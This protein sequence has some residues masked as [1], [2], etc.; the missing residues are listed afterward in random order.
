MQVQLLRCQKLLVTKRRGRRRNL[1]D[2]P[3]CYQIP[4]RIGKRS[5]FVM[6]ETQQPGLSL[7]LWYSRRMP[8][9]QLQRSK[10]LTT[11]LF[12]FPDSPSSLEQLPHLRAGFLQY[13]GSTQEYQDDKSKNA[14]PSIWMTARGKEDNVS[15]MSLMSGGSGGYTQSRLPRSATPV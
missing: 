10:S 7:R 15:G 9:R 5:L 13:V 8:R 3:R 6:P 2:S 1:L 11:L 12:L 14:S 4:L